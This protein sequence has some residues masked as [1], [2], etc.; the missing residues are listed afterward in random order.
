MTMGLDPLLEQS[1]KLDS[2]TRSLAQD[3]FASLPGFSCDFVSELFPLMN[4]P[5]VLRYPSMG[6]M[7]DIERMVV[8]GKPYSEVMA[9]LAVMIDKAPACWY[10][11]VSGETT[12]SLALARMPY[13]PAIIDLYSTYIKWRD[14]FR[15]GANG[16][17]P[18][19]PK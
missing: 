6:D 1:A 7:M 5:V 9:T 10:Q 11:L 18:T 4:G 3:P 8:R 17:A 12:P 16:G 14:S 19:P 2:R 15:P 13:D